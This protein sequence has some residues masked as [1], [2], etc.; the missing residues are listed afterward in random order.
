MPGKRWSPGGVRGGV[1]RD[2][3]DKAKAGLLEAQSPAV[4]VRTHRHDA[5][6]RCRVVPQ[7]EPWGWG[8][9]QGAE[10]RPMRTV[11]EM[12]GRPTSRSR[13]ATETYRGI[14]Y[15]ARALRRRSA[16]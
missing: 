16:R 11:K 13:R 15:G 12:S 8:N 10:R 2:P 14:A 1:L 4:R 3:R 5:W 6:S 7:H 9:L